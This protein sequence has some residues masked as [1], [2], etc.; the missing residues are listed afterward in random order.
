MTLAER[1]AESGLMDQVYRA[2]EA[3]H[4]DIGCGFVFD[5]GEGL[6]HVLTENHAEALHGRDPERYPQG[7]RDSFEPDMKPWV[8]AEQR[9]W[10]PL[11]IYHST[12]GARPEFSDR[13]RESAVLRLEGGLVLERNPGVCHLVV[14]V[15]DGRSDSSKLFRF[16][17]D[18]SAFDEI[19]EFDDSGRIT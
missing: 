17:D 19:A 13:N 15:T 10:I 14:R 8:Q 7:A 16:N 12:F 6:E 9:G 3:P 1:L 18:T 4:P 5:S 11:V 2:V